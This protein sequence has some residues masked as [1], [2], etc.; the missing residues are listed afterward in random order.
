MVEVLA[1]QFILA[2]GES[3]EC[4]GDNVIGLHCVELREYS[5]ISLLVDC[6]SLSSED[7]VSLVIYR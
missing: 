5:L 7:T 1:L 6:L 4:C 2:G 3:R